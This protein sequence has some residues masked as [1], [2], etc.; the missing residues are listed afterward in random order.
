MRHLVKTVACRLRP[1]FYGLE[2]NV[3]SRIA[4]HGD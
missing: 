2:Q 4:H 1:N 3:V